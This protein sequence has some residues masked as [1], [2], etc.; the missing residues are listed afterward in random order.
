MSPVPSLS[1]V[2]G[3]NPVEAGGFRAKSIVGESFAERSPRIQMVA[4]I[5][6]F[7]VED[8][9]KVVNVNGAIFALPTLGR[10]ETL[11]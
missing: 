11:S 10:S 4:I 6:Q 2:S 5:Q 8:G 7:L 9:R 3:H 1:K